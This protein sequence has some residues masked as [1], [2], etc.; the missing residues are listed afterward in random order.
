[1]NIHDSYSEKK[2][3]C[4]FFCNRCYF[5]YVENSNFKNLE[6]GEEGGAIKLSKLFNSTEYPVSYIRNNTFINNKAKSGGAI[7]LDRPNLLEVSDNI[8]TNNNATSAENGSGGAI[9]YRCDPT[10][11]EGLYNCTV[12]LTGNTFNGN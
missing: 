12:S 9:L 1:M 5:V 6:T 2:S 10:T 11:L 3:G 4:G 8:F 7:V